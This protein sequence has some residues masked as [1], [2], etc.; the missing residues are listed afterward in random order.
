MVAYDDTRFT[1]DDAYFSLSYDGTFYPAA[2]TGAQDQPSAGLSDH[3]SYHRVVTGDQPV[4]D[5]VLYDDS[6]ALY[7]DPILVYDQGGRAFISWHG[8]YHR[9]VTGLHASGTGTLT[10]KW[11]HR[12]EATYEFG[13]S[14]QP[15]RVTYVATQQGGN[16]RGLSY[17]THAE[18]IPHE[19]VYRDPGV[20]TYTT[21]D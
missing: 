2:L 9:V 4:A 7:D 13:I 21:E 10:R 8:S 1:Y 17:A 19:N 6:N 16:A 18:Q 11:T 12:P 20:R 14:D 15:D 3:G 5:I